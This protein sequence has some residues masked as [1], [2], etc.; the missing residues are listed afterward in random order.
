MHASAANRH[1]AP[2]QTRAPPQPGNTTCLPHCASAAPPPPLPLRVAAAKTCRAALLLLLPQSWGCCVRKRGWGGRGGGGSDT[3]AAAAAAGPAPPAAVCSALAGS[4]RAAAVTPL[5]EATMGCKAVSL[6]STPCKA[7]ESIAQ[8]G[9]GTGDDMPGQRRTFQAPD[10]RAEPIPKPN[11]AL[12]SKT[13][14]ANSFGGRR[15]PCALCPCGRAH[16]PFPS[17]KLR[18][19]QPQSW[20]AWR[21]RAAGASLGGHAAHDWA[22]LAALQR[23]GR[24]QGRG[25]RRGA[26]LSMSPPSPPLYSASQLGVPL[27]PL[28]AAHQPQAPGMSKQRQ[29]AAAGAQQSGSRRGAAE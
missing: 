25:S 3:C 22:R 1:L 21:R 19:R 8:G 20:C 12:A 26:R 14:P 9:Q 5:A 29:A 7:G 11:W 6:R 4:L 15:L 17:G 27:A 13:E 23:V 2:R 28:G 24:Q 18:T 10:L 16:R